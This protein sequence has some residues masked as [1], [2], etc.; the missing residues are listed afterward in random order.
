MNLSIVGDTVSDRDLYDDG[1][2]ERQSDQL[3][4]TV[5]NALEAMYDACE[6]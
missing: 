3:A 1:A 6:A 2:V 5:G 4:E